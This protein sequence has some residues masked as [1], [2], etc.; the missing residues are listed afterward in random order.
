VEAAISV[1][2]MRDTVDAVGFE[3]TSGS[4]SLKSLRVRVCRE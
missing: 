2:G 1:T 3:G 4:L